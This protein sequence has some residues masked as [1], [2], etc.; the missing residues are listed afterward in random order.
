MMLFSS[1][2]SV[3]TTSPV[4]I[5]SVPISSQGLLVE[6][7]VQSSTSGKVELT[8]LSLSV[9]RFLV[10]FDV[11]GRTSFP[12]TPTFPIPMRTP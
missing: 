6:R 3:Q 2:F 1:T 7:S 4:R 12:G 10:G 9:T 5:Q 11:L 8:A